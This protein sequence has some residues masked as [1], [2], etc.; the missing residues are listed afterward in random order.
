M[1]HANKKNIYLYLFYMSQILIGVLFL[2]IISLMI[3][4]Y[5]KIPLHIPIAGIIV[6]FILNDGIKMPTTGGE[7]MASTGTMIHTELPDF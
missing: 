2:I 3:N 6:Y 5:Y 4:K 7:N 1:T